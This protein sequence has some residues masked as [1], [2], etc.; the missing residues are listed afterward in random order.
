MVTEDAELLRDIAVFEP[1]HLDFVEVYYIGLEGRCCEKSEKHEVER[2]QSEERNRAISEYDTHERWNHI[3]SKTTEGNTVESWID[4]R[5][6]V[7][8]GLWLVDFLLL[9]L[10]R[11]PR[12]DST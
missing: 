2:S 12:A 5:C 1:G 7:D 9:P 8:V 11:H 4:H 6:D 3:S 10:I